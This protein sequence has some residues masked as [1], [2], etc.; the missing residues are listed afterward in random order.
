MNNCEAKIAVITGGAGV[1]CSAI[2]HGLARE[3]TSVVLLDLALD[4]A[5]VVAESI[6]SA[7][8]TAI[9]R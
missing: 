1:L 7:G 8:G 6:R 2:A 5:E 4:R 9:Q 3:G